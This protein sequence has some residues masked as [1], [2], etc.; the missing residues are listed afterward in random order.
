MFSTQAGKTMVCRL[1]QEFKGNKVLTLMG[2]AGR[3]ARK[4][5]G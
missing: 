3:G 5:A 1:G 2:Q 4:S